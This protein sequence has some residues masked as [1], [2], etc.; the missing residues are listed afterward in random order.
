MSKKIAFF[1]TAVAILVSTNPAE[2][3]QAG[4][5]HRIGYLTIRSAEQEQRYFPQVGDGV[6][7]AR[8]VLYEVLMLYGEQ[9]QKPVIGSH[10][11]DYPSDFAGI[12]SLHQRI[13]IC[14]GFDIVIPVL[15]SR[16]SQDLPLHDRP[17]NVWSLQNQFWSI[18]VIFVQSA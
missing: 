1:I 18:L 16:V 7:Y 6:Y 14:H 8:L 3:Q 9:P 13:G 15:Q 17:F 12:G 2:A 10:G 5:V 4:K 11:F